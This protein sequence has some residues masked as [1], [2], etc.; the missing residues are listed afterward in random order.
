[1]HFQQKCAN[2]DNKNGPR[3]SLT[4]ITSLLL[5]EEGPWAEFGLDNAEMRRTPGRR[6]KLVAHF[7]ISEH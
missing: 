7:L 3:P 2:N 4:H 5:V 6:A 1:M